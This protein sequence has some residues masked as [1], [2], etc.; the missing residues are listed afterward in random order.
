MDNDRFTEE[1][2]QQI[3]AAIAMAC[4]SDYDS[5]LSIEIEEFAHKGC[6]LELERLVHPEK[7]GCGMRIKI[8]QPSFGFLAKYDLDYHPINVSPGPHTVCVRFENTNYMS[9]DSFTKLENIFLTEQEMEIVHEYIYWIWEETGIKAQV[10]RMITE[11][12]ANVL[13]DN[14]T[15]TDNEGWRPVEQDIGLPPDSYSAVVEFHNAFN[16]AVG[17]RVVWVTN[18]IG[19]TSHEE[20]VDHEYFSRTNMQNLAQISGYIIHGEYFII[21][22]VQ[23]GFTSRAYLISMTENNDQNLH[24]TN[25]TESFCM[26]IDHAIKLQFT[27]ANIVAIVN[28]YWNRNNEI[29]FID[30]V[31]SSI[32]SGNYNRIVQI[33]RNEVLNIDLLVLNFP[34]KFTNNEHRSLIDLRLEEHENW[35]DE[36][37]PITNPKSLEQASGRLYDCLS[38]VFHLS[39]NSVLEVTPRY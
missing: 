13:S 33:S 25:Q 27:Q 18:G 4:I 32:E 37:I 20:L 7:T 39:S 22:L 14:S 35:F 19:G 2:L 23:L 11:L 31:F 10:K 6:D 3:L 5:K 30:L 8:K 21:K 17:H 9:E 15:E 36:F 38:K 29:T 24:I 12:D 26:H 34:G 1:Q 28:E 16:L